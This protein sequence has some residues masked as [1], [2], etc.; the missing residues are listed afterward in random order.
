[1]GAPEPRA[2]S[3]LARAERLVSDPLSDRALGGNPRA[4]ALGPALAPWALAAAGAAASACVRS[5][6]RDAPATTLLAALMLGDPSKVES[7]LAHA[8]VCDVEGGIRR[9]ARRLDLTGGAPRDS[10]PL[11]TALVLAKHCAARHAAGDSRDA[12]AGRLLVAGA[13]QRLHE[14][15]GSSGTHG[16]FAELAT[17]CAPL[18]AVEVLHKACALCALEPAAG[19]ARGG[20]P[21]QLLG[22]LCR[23]ISRHG[24][25]M[26]EGDCHRVVAALRAAAVGTRLRADQSGDKAMRRRAA[27]LQRAVDSVATQLM[28]SNNTN[29]EHAGGMRAGASPH[30]SNS[31]WLPA[32]D[33]MPS[34]ADALAIAEGR[35]ASTQS[36]P[37]LSPF[38]EGGHAPTL[39]VRRALWLLALIDELDRVCE[40]ADVGCVGARADALE[41]AIVGQLSSRNAVDSGG[42]DTLWELC[43]GDLQAR[44]S[45][46]IPRAHIHREWGE[47]DEASTDGC[48]PGRAKLLPWRPLQ[49][50]LFILAEKE[51]LAVEAC[52][53][54][55]T[56]RLS[57]E[58][59]GVAPRRLRVLL[60]GALAER[61]VRGT[62]ATLHTLH[63]V[64][65]ARR[66]CTLLG[67]PLEAGLDADLFA[68]A[69]STDAC[70]W[71]VLPAL[72]PR[73]L[74]RQVISSA[75]E[76]LGTSQ[77]RATQAAGAAF[78]R[79]AL[80][81]LDDRMVG[82]SSSSVGSPWSVSECAHWAMALVAKGTAATNAL[83]LSTSDRALWLL[84]VARC[85]LE[86]SSLALS[87][88]GQAAHDR[89]DLRLELQTI[90]RALGEL[91]ATQEGSGAG[92]ACRT[93][94][95]LDLPPGLRQELLRVRRDA[96]VRLA[97]IPV[98]SIEA[99]GSLPPRKRARL[100]GHEGED[101][102]HPAALAAVRLACVTRGVAAGDSGAAEILGAA[103]EEIWQN[104]AEVASGARDGRWPRAF[105]GDLLSKTV[106]AAASSD[107]VSFIQGS[108]RRCRALLA[109]SAV[110]PEA[111]ATVATIS[112]MLC[113]RVPSGFLADMPEAE[114]VALVCCLALGAGR[115]SSIGDADEVARVLIHLLPAFTRCDAG[116]GHAAIIDTVATRLAP[117]LDVLCVRMLTSLLAA[118]PQLR[119]ALVAH[120]GIADDSEGEWAKVLNRDLCDVLKECASCD[121]RLDEALATG[122]LK[123][124]PGASSALVGQ[125]VCRAVLHG[126][127][128]VQVGA[129]W[130]CQYAPFEDADAVAATEAIISAADAFETK[131]A[132]GDTF[133]V[134]TTCSC[135]SSLAMRFATV[136][137][138]VLARS[139]ASLRR[140]A[141]GGG[142]D[143]SS[144]LSAP[145]WAA[146]VAGALHAVASHSPAMVAAASADFCGDILKLAA[147]TANMPQWRQ[148]VCTLLAAVRASSP[149]ASADEKQVAAA[150]VSAAAAADGTPRAHVLGRECSSQ[151]VA[152]AAAAATSGP[153]ARPLRAQ[154]FDARR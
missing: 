2:E 48:E 83:A 118:A 139:V 120:I 58:A 17:A 149:W 96:S 109:M 126:D 32:R 142:S 56:Q 80:E 143:A 28:G 112:P 153:L 121:V 141:L 61:T 108:T 65:R 54:A 86:A 3:D 73:D 146:A 15:A 137:P 115:T 59:T 69:V 97:T 111:N 123:W 85:A 8:K 67:Y 127:K 93:K 25:A 14:V 81:S 20:A 45:T 78:A 77:L 9:A 1:M 10:V 13:A 122:R 30:T 100:S 36:V 95:S 26:S 94:D 79:K 147:E 4:P 72:V 33:Y 148:C 150:A 70:L 87:L 144:A 23:S 24:G 46:E 41:A 5:A 89:R 42:D 98:P 43:V 134:P 88:G 103:L 71:A 101:A 22:K 52:A 68:R 136:V 38:S 154:C 66:A 76:S 37:D 102:A 132:A 151:A 11:C 119:D 104:R 29:N 105:L 92:G 90:V 53:A 138:P 75:I 135:L 74:R 34:V 145:R 116:K 18:G 107:P 31:Q 129:S 47:P 40:D 125:D 91:L 133:D 140:S 113:A 12:R 60:S 7:V 84:Q 51:V 114:Q 35:G 19:D 16:G 50:V 99:E 44:A 110:F 82:E 6:A 49:R 128:D 130:L 21:P 106:A 62:A 63:I 117:A 57:R 27:A 39:Y 55:Q 152:A 124:P 64:S 131:P